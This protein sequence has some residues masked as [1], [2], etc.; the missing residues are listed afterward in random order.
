MTAVR[1][2][3]Q[4]F[5][6]N[7]TEAV[8][9]RDSKS[10]RAFLDNVESKRVLASLMSTIDG[11]SDRGAVLIAA[12]HV[13]E[14]LRL[15]F[16][17]LAPVDMGRKRLVRILAYPGPL[18][19]TAARTDIARVTRLLSDSVCDSIDH[20]RR[21]RNS[22]AHG[23]RAFCLREH[24]GDVHGV[25]SFAAGLQQFVNRMACEM[26]VGSAVDSL[27][28]LN[29]PRTSPKERVF[30]SRREVME[31]LAAKPKTTAPLDQRRPRIELALGTWILCGMVIFE[32]DEML[33][34]LGGSR[35][36]YAVSKRRH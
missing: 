26:L 18:S 9:K 15:L 8:S 4:G 33:R 31:Y 13:E 28:K 11:E 24:A 35:M 1:R 12:A 29:K 34:T 7:G 16:E 30:R 3:A 6:R 25:F 5:A 23:P 22:V 17:R 36:W 20:L 21:L 27:L 2:H 32:R 14:Q 10:G 19:T